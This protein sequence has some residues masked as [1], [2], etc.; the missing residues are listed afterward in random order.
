MF[1]INIVRSDGKSFGE[2]EPIAA[3]DLPGILKVLSKPSMFGTG[4]F[5]F[6]LIPC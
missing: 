4:A 1:K 5:Q 2:T 6:V 3:D